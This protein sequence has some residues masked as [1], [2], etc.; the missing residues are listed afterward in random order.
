MELTDRLKQIWASYKER[1][2]IDE[3]T[4]DQTNSAAADEKVIHSNHVRINRF[5]FFWIPGKKWTHSK[6]I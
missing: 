5:S 6:L 3:H 2:P 4:I 1:V